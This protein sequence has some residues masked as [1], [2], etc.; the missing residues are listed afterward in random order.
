GER[1]GYGKGEVGGVTDS[2]CAAHK[3]DAALR[4][5]QKTKAEEVLTKAKA[6]APTDTAAFATLVR[7]NSQNQRTKPMDGDSRFISEADLTSQYGKEVA[8]AAVNMKR[9]GELSEVIETPT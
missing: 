1:D 4:K 2:V 3:E 9:A 7:E 5:K 6:I 8:T